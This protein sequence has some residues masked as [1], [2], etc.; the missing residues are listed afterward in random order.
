MSA[1][2]DKPAEEQESIGKKQLLQ[3]YR[4]HASIG[5]R[6]ACK[7]KCILHGNCV[8]CVEWHRD[9]ARGP[10]VYCVKFDEKVSFE[11]YDDLRNIKTFENE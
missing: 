3:K 2:E 7:E 8:A 6:C 10:L 11:R 1:I 9:H 5:S 4:D